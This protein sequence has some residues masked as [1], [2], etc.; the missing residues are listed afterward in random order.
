MCKFYAQTR[1]V[2]ELIFKENVSL[3]IGR[4]LGLSQ[5]EQR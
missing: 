3:P 2:P 5:M 1:A 4:G